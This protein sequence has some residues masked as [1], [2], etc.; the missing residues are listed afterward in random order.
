M[1]YE[2]K[3]YDNTTVSSATIVDWG[4]FFRDVCANHL[5]QNPLKIGDKGTIVEIDETV[6]VRRKY[7]RGKNVSEQWIFGGVE[8]GSG[9]C[10]LVP[11]EHRNADTLLPIIQKHILPNTTIML[12]LGKAYFRIGELPK[13]YRQLTV[14]NSVN[15]GDP[16]SDVCTNTIKSTWQKFKNE[17]KKRFGTHR[18]L[19]LTYMS[20]FMWRKTLGVCVL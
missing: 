4:N 19:F 2:I 9:K 14:N 13:K 10:F 1:F 17:H 5:L 8:R 20:N 12:D 15:F 11:V 6:L 18:S 3:R 7:N 16:D